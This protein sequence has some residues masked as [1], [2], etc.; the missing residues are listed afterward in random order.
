MN[1]LKQKHIIDKK[2]LEESRRTLIQNSFIGKY[3]HDL[4]QTNVHGIN[5][6]TNDYTTTSATFEHK[7]LQLKQTCIQ[8]EKIINGNRDKNGD[9]RRTPQNM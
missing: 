2:N 3:L 5:K 1:S 7:Q 9:S 8:L 4:L 6:V